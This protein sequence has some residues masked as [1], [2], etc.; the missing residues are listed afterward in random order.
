MALGARP[1]HTE[2]RWLALLALLAVGGIV[3]A[4]P[5]SLTLGPPWLVL[6]LVAGLLVPTVISHRR[7]QHALNHV[8][9]TLA[10]AITSLMTGTAY[11]RSAELAAVVGPYD[12]YERNASAHKRVMRK[13][14]DACAEIRTAGGIDSDVHAAAKAAAGESVWSPG[15]VD[16]LFL[17]F[18]TSTALSPTDAPVLSPWA[19]LLMM[20]QATI[21]LTIVVLLAAR[22]VNIL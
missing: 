22:A 11:R 12:G 19:K 9:Q 3:M 10:A 21:S 7:E 1:E 17:A 18:N 4:L 6:V 20:L 14:A 8:G 15:F 2:P 5:A 13:H 16:Y